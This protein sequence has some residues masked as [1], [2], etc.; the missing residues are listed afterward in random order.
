MARLQVS[1]HILPTGIS[2]ITLILCA[3]ITP[4]CSIVITCYVPHFGH[5]VT[6]E[7]QL[8]L[9]NS[10]PVLHLTQTNVTSPT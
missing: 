10:R 6:Y 7:I 9:P 1:G 8:A 4:G 5:E 2:C 3:S